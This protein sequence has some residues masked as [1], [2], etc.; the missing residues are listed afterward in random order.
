MSDP[1][2]P[3]PPAGLPGRI[4][5]AEIRVPTTVFGADLRFLTEALGFRLDRIWP[6]ERPAFAS[7]SGHGTALLLERTD[8]PAPVEFRL[9]AEEPERLLGGA[10][11]RTS[12]GGHRIRLVPV[13]PRLRVPPASREFVVS[14]L[15][16]DAF[17]PGRAGM[18]YRDLLP[19]RLGG[20]VIASHIRIP[21]GGPVRD[22]VH[23]HTIVFQL[24]FCHRGWVRLVYEDQ[25][26]PFVLHAGDCVIQPP[27]I[28]HQVLEAS[29]GLEVIEIGVPA[30][31]LTSM[32]HRMTLPTP[33]FRPARDFAG[34][35]FLRHREP[36]ARW[37][38]GR[39]PGFRARE[40]GIG[41]AT[42]GLAG[43][44]V[45]RRV[46]GEPVPVTRHDAEILL[47]FVRSGSLTLGVGGQ[48]DERLAS[49][50]AFALP[51]GRPLTIREPSDDLEILEVALPAGFT[52][53]I[54]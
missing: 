34:T 11:E 19:G 30:D 6:A 38:G 8:R 25:G 50:A 35:R 20:A 45:V 43:V 2:A 23:F 26:P 13:R 28:R 1:A 51:P 39:I 54:R 10:A 53:E 7:L 5:R 33:R 47:G 3:E 16:D 4:R 24:I 9:Y 14:R 12:P 40:T 41:A 15:E 46:P 17:G 31:H 42:G 36:E 29:V 48:P 44:R 32:D 22:Q 27:E 49:G 18:Q 21:E 37:E 52:T